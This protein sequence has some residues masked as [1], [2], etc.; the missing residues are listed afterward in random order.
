MTGS[1]LK[2]AVRFKGR[3]LQ[4]KTQIT[5]VIAKEGWVSKTFRYT[6]RPGRFPRLTLS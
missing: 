6:T 1:K 3:K 5:I 4:A 2:L